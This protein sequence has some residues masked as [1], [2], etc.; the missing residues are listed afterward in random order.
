MANFSLGDAELTT[1][2][3]LDGLRDGLNDAEKTSSEGGNRAGSALGKAMAAGVAAAAV[4][5]VAAVGAVVAS[6]VSYASEQGAA[7]RGLQAS[8]GIAAEEAER[9]G[10]I[11]EDTFVKGFGES[12]TEATEAIGIVEKR[13]GMLGELTDDELSG[14]TQNAFRLRDAFGV[15]IQESVNAASVLMEHFGLTQQQAFDFI[16]KG[17]QQGLNSSDDF[18]DSI[19][20]YSNQ[21]AELDADAGQFFSALQT[22]MQGGPL[23]TDKI[24]D[25]F[26]ETRLRISEETDATREALTAIGI[27]ADLFYAGLRDGSLTGIEAFQQIQGALGMVTDPIAQNTAA[28][29]LMGTQWED[30]GA[31][32][33][34]A[35]DITAVSLDDMAGATDSLNVQYQSLGHM[36]EIASRQMLVSI[37]PLGEGLLQLA[38]MV[39]PHIMAAI[40]ALQPI[41]A[42]LVASIQA[43]FGWISQYLT[44]NSGAITGTLTTAWTSIQ[45]AVSSVTAI[46]QSIVQTVFGIV[47]TFIANHGTEI[48]ATLQMAWDTIVMV[49]D[50]AMIIIQQAIIPALAAIVAFIQSHSDTIQAVLSNAWTAIRSVIQAALTLIQGIVKAVLALIQGD[51]SGAWKIIQD[52]SAKFVQL[53][54]TAIKA[55]LDNI[56][57]VWTTIWEGLK[58]FYQGI[59]D[60]LVGW[61]YQTLQG[62]VNALNSFIGTARSAAGGVGS[63]II[64]G[65]TSGIENGVGAIIDAAKRAAMAALNAAKK[66]LGISSPSKKFRAIGVNSGESFGLGI[67]DSLPQVEMA[68]DA[69]A[70]SA[71]SAALDSINTGSEQNW[72]VTAHYGYQPE[73]RMR[74]DVRMLQLL[75]STT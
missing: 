57:L 18:L 65:I 9:L 47:A 54:W 21:F 70:N 34:L 46:I 12:I 61:L 52:M 37:A 49:I 42:G 3:N 7:V 56:L 51:F 8:L 74:D 19:G 41:I 25:L 69:L 66:A 58:V 73:K 16:A 62:M 67:I 59:L 11:A 36:W 17:F 55:G 71:T 27:D 2:V 29:A 22:G 6:A 30:L 63:A 28:I 38:N 33:V 10:D 68:S 4:L 35:A 44:Q 43:A 1:S 50:A 24:A 15:D 23:G 14:A 26:K 13:M 31:N 5:V 32:A 48:M 72:N 39:M 60:S 40:A 64:G 75:G 45:A 20:E 53:L